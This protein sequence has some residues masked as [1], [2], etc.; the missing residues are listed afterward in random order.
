[1]DDGWWKKSSVESSSRSLLHLDNT[2]RAF[3]YYG[4]GQKEK[5]PHLLLASSITMSFPS[6]FRNI[7]KV[8]GD[9]FKATCTISPR[10]V[11][12]NSLK[13]INSV[14]EESLTHKT[15]TLMLSSMDSYAWIRGFRQPGRSLRAPRGTRH[16]AA[17]INSPPWVD[18]SLNMAWMF[19]VYAMDDP[20]SWGIFVWWLWLCGSRCWSL[21]RRREMYSMNVSSCC[22]HSGFC[23]RLLCH[24][25]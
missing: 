16:I 3:S 5:P 20:E 9:W 11:R 18:S 14:G 2:N 4:L 23:S 15:R 19:L 12:W 7:T 22:L 17:A 24:C 25:W 21:G 8:Y 6:F 13:V 1:M 10:K